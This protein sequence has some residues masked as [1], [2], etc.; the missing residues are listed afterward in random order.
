MPPRDDF[1]NSLLGDRAP[2]CWVPGTRAPHRR[3][4]FTW[5][6]RAGSRGAAPPQGRG[7]SR[8]GWWWIAPRR[9]GGGALPW[10]ARAPSRAPNARGEPPR[11]GGHPPA[12]TLPWA[13]SAPVPGSGLCDPRLGARR[14]PRGRRGSPPPAAS[15]PGDWG[16]GGHSSGAGTTRRR[17]PAGPAR[18][19]NARGEPPRLGRH[20]PGY[21]PIC[22]KLSRLVPPSLAFPNHT[23]SNC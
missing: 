2:P 11:P 12:H 7:R 23:A 22:I 19:P 3:P 21:K 4:A 10:S 15:G 8:R 1:S 20:P 5:A 18:S 9:S 16:E 17:P 13:R 14:R 6:G